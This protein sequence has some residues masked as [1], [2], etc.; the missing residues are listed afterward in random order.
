MVNTTGMTKGQVHSAVAWARGR[1]DAARPIATQIST[2]VASALSQSGIATQFGERLDVLVVPARAG[3][4]RRSVLDQKAFA[5]W[6][7][8]FKTSGSVTDAQTASQ[9][10]RSLGDTRLAEAA[11]AVILPS[12]DIRESDSFADAIVSGIPS[13]GDG[14]ELV[15]V[16]KPENIALVGRANAL[17]AEAQ[18]NENPLVAVL[19]A[20]KQSIRVGSTW[21]SSHEGL[22]IQGRVGVA[23]DLRTRMPN[24]P[25]REVT[26]ELLAVQAKLS[27]IRNRVRL[28]KHE[29]SIGD[30]HED[31]FEVEQVPSFLA[32]GP[33]IA[34]AEVLRSVTGRDFDADRIAWL[35]AY[36]EDAA[37]RLAD[38]SQKEKVR[39]FRRRVQRALAATAD[40]LGV[41]VED[42]KREIA[43]RVES[44]SVLALK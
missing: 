18:A 14:R 43:D 44:H 29:T 35:G 38:S 4:R 34:I 28:Q 31:T 42:V 39:D 3:I 26:I 25:A 19:L 22:A 5:V 11:I 32:V 16:R 17:L 1:S 9:M 33:E 23:Q 36:A 2:E 10:A 8:T 6:A 27:S 30:W 20:R 41:E 21:E 12:K 13:R 24:D 37:H 7:A 40:E 15:G